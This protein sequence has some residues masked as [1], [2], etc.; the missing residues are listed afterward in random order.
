MEEFNKR[1]NDLV[2]S[3]PATIK[4]TNASLLIYYIQ[5]F[6]GKITYQIRDKE[7]TDL[8]DAEEKFIKI[9][10]NMQV[11][12]ESNVLGFSRGSSSK[13]QEVKKVKVE[14]QEIQGD[15]IDKITQLMK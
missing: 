3:L 14:N 11:A 13:S 6:E 10:K 4:P 12:G 8:R 1:F 9:E 2:K 15:S 5:A 7:P